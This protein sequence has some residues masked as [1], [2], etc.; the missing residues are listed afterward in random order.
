M[1]LLHEHALAPLQHLRAEAARFQAAQ[2]VQHR[3]HKG[4]READQKA[5]EVKL[6]ARNQVRMAFVGS[7][8]VCACAH[9]CVLGENM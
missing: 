2:L 4:E 6:A 7:V 5:A 8:C 9:M 3:R 1:E